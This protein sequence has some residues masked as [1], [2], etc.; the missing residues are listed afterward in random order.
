MPTYTFEAS[1]ESCPECVDQDGDS[2]DSGGGPPPK[3]HQN[4]ECQWTRDDAKTPQLLKKTTKV[5]K[6][7]KYLGEVL[8]YVT[9]GQTTVIT[10]G[11]SF[12]ENQSQ[13]GGT[14]GTLEESLAPG[15][16]GGKGSVTYSDAN[17]TGTTTTTLHESRTTIAYDDSVPGA[18]H[19][20]YAEY[21]DVTTTTESTYAMPSDDNEGSSSSVT[22]SEFTVRQTSTER[23]FVGY[24]QRD[25]D[26]ADGP[27]AGEDDSLP[28]GDEDDDLP[29]GDEDDEDDEL[30]DGDGD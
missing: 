17:T 25:S 26:P 24:A 7:P 12:A 10:E 18:T 3:P 16:I 4:C 11:K 1:S 23:V 15:G 13:T 30:P 27:D 21:R 22:V 2:M 14:A 6:G 5:T 28:D 20:I 8:G 19:T 9:Q 29:D